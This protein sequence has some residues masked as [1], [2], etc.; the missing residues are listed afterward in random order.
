ML[1]SSRYLLR[2][3]LKYIPVRNNSKQ[4]AQ[5][6]LNGMLNKNSILCLSTQTENPTNDSN[7]ASIRTALI[8]LVGASLGI[9]YLKSHLDKAY[10]EENSQEEEEE[11]KVDP[12]KFIDSLP[13]YTVDDLKQ[14]N[15]EGGR[16]WVSYKSGV[17]DITD[18]IEGHPGG[19]IIYAGAGKSLEPFWKTY[20]VHHTNETYALLEEYRIGNLKLEES[21]AHDT[22]PFR[23]DP[24]RSS[25][26]NVLSSKP[27]NAESPKQ[28]SVE[29][30]ITPNDLHFKRNHLPVPHVN[31]NE[32]ELEIVDEINGK[33]YKFKL[34]ELKKKY[35]IYTIPVTL[36]CSGNKR[37]HMNAVEPVQ[38]LMWDVTAISTANWTG[39]KLV[40]LLNDLKIDLNDGKYKHV[41]FEGLDR[42]P[43]G[44]T[45]GA[46]IP[47][48]K[49]FDVNNDVLVAF[50]MNGVDIPL[51]RKFDNNGW[52]F[53]NATKFISFFKTPVYREFYAL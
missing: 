47:K 52:C 18:F 15:K 44:A 5:R 28:A 31:V 1:A 11:V 22:D 30:L 8:A 32:F 29:N 19:K 48:E 37:K 3:G 16:I 42:G 20:A 36:Q 41:Q 43:T 14:H 39:F 45:Y 51:D 53:K 13:T 33:S 6:S 21:A 12:G 24:A 49:A 46:S 35:S 2:T 27:F 17:Y 34:D 7:T 23:L 26:L 10:C 9:G 25:L 40:D 38:G 4:Q 50:Q